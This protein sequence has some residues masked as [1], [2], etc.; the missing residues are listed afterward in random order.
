MSAHIIEYAHMKYARILCPVYS[1]TAVKHIVVIRLGIHVNTRIKRTRMYRE[2]QR[3][4]SGQKLMKF[5]RAYITFIIVIIIIFNIK[6]KKS[7]P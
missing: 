6:K 3:S 2:I 7:S 5:P 1:V 4:S